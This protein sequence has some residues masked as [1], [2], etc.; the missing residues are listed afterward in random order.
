M[1]APEHDAELTKWIKTARG[2][3]PMMFAYI[4]K[5]QGGKLLV[6]KKI[7]PKT[8]ADAKKEV[9][10]NTVIRGRVVGEQ[11][12][13]Y[14]EVAKEVPQ[15]LPL[16]IKRVIKQDTG[17]VLDCLVRMKDD[18][19]AELK[20]EEG[21]E[22]TPGAPATPATAPATPGARPTAPGAPATAQTAPG[23]P[24]TAQAPDTA[25][26]TPPP[27][28]SAAPRAP[29]VPPAPPLPGT[30]GAAVMKRINALKAG[31]AAAIA[32]KSPD[33]SRIQSLFVAV[34]GLAKNLDYEQA[35]KV[36]DELEPLVKRAAGAPAAPPSPATV[37]KRFNALTAGLKA[38]IAA[39]GPDV[40]RIQALFVALNGS[41]KS[42]DFTHAAKLL[43]ELEP[44]L[45]EAKP[46][47]PATPGAS[48]TLGAK[49]GAP[50]TPGAPPTPGATPSVNPQA[51]YEKR[52]ADLK[53][54][55][56][57]ALSKGLGDTGK[58]R[59]VMAYAT[60]QAEAGQFAKSLVA[61][62]QLEPLV[63]AALSGKA[64]KETDVIPKGVVEARKKFVQS[65]WQEAVST[66]RGEVEKLTGAIVEQ[67][68]DEDADEL[69]AAIQDHLSSFY[70]ELN[71]A[72]LNAQA[73]DVGNLTPLDRALETV[74]KY[75]TLV[76]EDDLIK[77]L[78]QARSDLG[79]D[80]A[81][82]AALLDALG[83]VETRFE[84]VK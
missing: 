4:A 62:K 59:A 71:A 36:L 60:E 19:E 41:I 77:H 69:V 83:E 58:M 21:E 25:A 29:G 70:D 39:K 12:T 35:G 82:E 24:A 2:G 5:A 51:D 54:R 48:S 72:I 16:Q 75:K 31:L 34:N 18:A 66:V 43:D 68:P 63:T 64:G 42:E 1:A 11:G 33:L 47:A 49:P 78:N 65:R 80:I 44:I 56:D 57:E 67:V 15:A 40:A 53:P 79:V 30:P 3:R 52:L 27:G 8:I 38:A 9:G 26:P 37:M 55:F 84:S 10:S 22:T 74:R 46:G 76:K 7:L 14:F 81:V 20:E 28:P 6:G 45:A 23:G 17:L 32:A 61:L 50:A 13:L 73:A